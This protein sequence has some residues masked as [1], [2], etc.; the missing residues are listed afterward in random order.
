MPDATTSALRPI[1]AEWHRRALPIIATKAFIDTWADFIVAWERVKY[2]A[3]A[4]PVDAAFARAAA[5]A[6]PAKAVQLYRDGPILLL[7]ALCRELQGTA[8]D[9]DFY[10]DVRT[11]GRLL[12][13][14]HSTAWRWL[15][16]L[17]AEGILQAG[18][19]GSKATRKASR[20]R[21]LG[22]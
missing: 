8:G 1:I 18:E 2:P 17:C 5:S 4:S 7:A 3:G 12:N 22:D 21:Y 16:V 10:L 13:V 19:I 11:A 20:F 14:D 15:K 6:P 9:G